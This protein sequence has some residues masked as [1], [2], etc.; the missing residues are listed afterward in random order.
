MLESELMTEKF[1]PLQF[2][3]KKSSKYD[4]KTLC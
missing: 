1:T 4:R 3:I 2:K